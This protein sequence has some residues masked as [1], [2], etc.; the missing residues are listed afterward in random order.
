MGERRRVCKV[1]VGK[2]ERKKLLGTPRR[3]WDDYTKMELRK[4]DEGMD[5]IY[6]A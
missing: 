6:L 5:W 3:K 2:H 1:L 4:W